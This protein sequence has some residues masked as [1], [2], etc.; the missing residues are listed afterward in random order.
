[1]F[2]VPADRWNKVAME[3]DLQTAWARE[4]FML[5]QE[6][7]DAAIEK[8]QSEL[9]EQGHPSGVICGFQVLLPLLLEGPALVNQAR[10]DPDLAGVFLEIDSINS[11]LKLAVMDYRLTKEETSE[12]RTLLNAAVLSL[13]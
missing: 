8:E 5:S 4:R 2:N 3:E 12:L 9:R 6:E 13:T 10:K 7:L 1:M 11:A